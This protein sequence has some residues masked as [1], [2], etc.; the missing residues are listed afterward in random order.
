MIEIRIGDKLDV[1]EFGTKIRQPIEV[2]DISFD[3]Y[4]TPELPCEV[5]TSGIA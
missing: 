4:I 2:T 1:V 5:L 3:G